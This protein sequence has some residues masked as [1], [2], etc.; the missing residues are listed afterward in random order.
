MTKVYAYNSASLYGRRL[1]RA[2]D[3]EF[4]RAKIDTYKE[5]QSR[6][7]TA[8]AQC[9]TNK[10]RFIVPSN[11]AGIR[12]PFVYIEADIE[13][14]IGDFGDGITSLNFIHEKGQEVPLVYAEP[15]SDET[16]KMLIDAGLY[17]DRQFE[18]LFSRIA[19]GEMFDAV[20]PLDLQLLHVESE[21]G[22][23]V[24]IVLANP[25]QSVHEVTPDSDY[26]SV[27]MLLQTTAMLAIELEKEGVQTSELVKD[28]PQFDDEI[29]YDKIEDILDI[30]EEQTDMFS[31]EQDEETEIRATSNPFNEEIDVTNVLDGL[32]IN[33]SEEDEKIQLFKRQVQKSQEV[34]SDNNETDLDDGLD[35]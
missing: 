11:N 12:R 28:V 14:V 13:E 3:T 30:A 8:V 21:S 10:V 34:P 1:R 35:Y 27:Q 2:L 6:T 25:V 22:K 19:D 26:T 23:L 7:I 17:R 18:Q 20:V 31:F 5:L 15:I 24:P 29:S 33:Q 16:L 4:S 9:R 32:F